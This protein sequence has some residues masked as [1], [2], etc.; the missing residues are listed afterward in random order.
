MRARFRAVSAAAPKPSA[1]VFGSWDGGRSRSFEIV[2]IQIIQ[3][4]L[5]RFVVAAS[6]LAYLQCLFRGWAASQ[7]IARSALADIIFS[8]IL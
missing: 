1:V 4:Y 8:N 6:G 5:L 3:Y 7:A 2:C